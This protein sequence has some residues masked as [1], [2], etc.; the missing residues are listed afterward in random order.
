MY[1]R[2]GAL[3]PAAPLEIVVGNILPADLR[4]DQILE[5]TTPHAGVV[6]IVDEVGQVIDLD[7]HLFAGYAEMLACHVL[8]HFLPRVPICPFDDAFEDMFLAHGFSLKRRSV[9]A[10]PLATS[11]SIAV[12]R[13]AISLNGYPALLVHR[14][15]CR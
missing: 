6:A 4:R 11:L 9:F 3:F 15:R 12:L 8:Q 13:D 7:A 1:A 2:A 10:L 14:K 5:G